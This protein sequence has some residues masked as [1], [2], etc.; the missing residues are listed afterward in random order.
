MSAI[1][2]HCNGE[3]SGE[4]SIWIEGKV[5]N[6]VYFPQTEKWQGKLITAFL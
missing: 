3:E 2:G 6:Q 1:K 5:I 4:D